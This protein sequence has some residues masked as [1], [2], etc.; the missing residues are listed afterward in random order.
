MQRASHVLI[1]I[2][3]DSAASHEADQGWDS[4]THFCLHCVTSTLAYIKMDDTSPLPPARSSQSWSHWCRALA[5]T[6]GDPTE[7]DSVVNHEVEMFIWRVQALWP[8][9]HPATRGDLQCFGLTF[10]EQSRRSSLLQLMNDDDGRLY[11]T[12]LLKDVRCLNSRGGFWCTRE[13]QTGRVA[14]KRGRIRITLHRFGYLW[15]DANRALVKVCVLAQSRLCLPFTVIS[16]IFLVFSSIHFSRRI[17]S[18]ALMSSFNF[19]I[20]CRGRER[21]EEVNLWWFGHW[22]DEDT[23]AAKEGLLHDDR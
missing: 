23:L 16:L 6:L 22:S 17:F 9:V 12:L 15:P 2:W 20:S 21:V 1:M 8:L 11:A 3:A 19:L 5:H 14:A 18:V 4:L 10:G 13:E 7:R